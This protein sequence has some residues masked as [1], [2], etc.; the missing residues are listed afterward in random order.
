MR[1]LRLR[2]PWTMRVGDVQ[3]A[4]AQGLGLG[5]GEGAFQQRQAQPA[6]QVAGD[7]GGQAPGPI[8]L[9]R[10][11]GQLTEAGLL[12][13]ADAVFDSGVGTVAGFEELGGCAGGVGG[14]E[15]VASPV[16]LLEQGELRA[17]VGFFAAGDDAQIGG[18]AC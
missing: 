14:Q 1:I 17:G 12:A 8:D 13:G 9:D 7:G 5:L 18:P 10:G 11:R 16:G 4:V 2:W 15:L 6:Q 3:Q